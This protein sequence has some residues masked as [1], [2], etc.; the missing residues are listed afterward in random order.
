MRSSR[1]LA[2]GQWAALGPDEQDAI[3][4]ASREPDGRRGAWG[5]AAEQPFA[6]LEVSR[7]WCGSMKVLERGGTGNTCGRGSDG[8]RWA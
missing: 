3:G 7:G 1:Q 4:R 5:M 6:H 2:G 8:F